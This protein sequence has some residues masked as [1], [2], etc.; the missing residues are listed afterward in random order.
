M[1]KNPYST[2]KK[3]RSPRHTGIIPALLLIT[4]LLAGC[5]QL[6]A[7]R[8]TEPEVL[9]FVTK[10]P[11]EPTQPKDTTAPRLIGVRNL[12]VYVGDI[13]S[14]LTGI[15]AEDDC[16]PNPVISVDSRFVDLSKAGTYDVAYT[17]TDSAG[18]S[19]GAMAIITVLEREDDFIDT[20]TIYAAVDE[21]LNLLIPEDATAEE[22]VHAIYAWARTSLSYGGHSD[23]TDW[24]QTAYT[25]L[26]E[27]RGDCFGFYAVTKLMFERLGIPNIDVRKVKNQKTD[28]D[29]FWSLVSVDGGETYYHFDATPRSGE[30]D[31]FC[32]VT[33]AFLD[34]YSEKHRNSHNRDESLYPT[35]PEEA[36]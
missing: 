28:S 36:L 20:E 12:T 10:P 4:G 21:R 16:D 3:R 25:M 15:S 30:G 2:K 23:Q 5:M 13:I 34:A 8:P 22:Q 26:T 24:M 31:D 9:E 6:L 33:D 29:H 14:Y 11:T 19:S 32:L 27:G 18:N 17:A 7:E 35:T 1:H